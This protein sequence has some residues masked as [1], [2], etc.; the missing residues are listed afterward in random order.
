[1]ATYVVPQIWI[2]YDGVVS[3]NHWFVFAWLGQVA[4]TDQC[5]TLKSFEMLNDRSSRLCSSGV[6]LIQS[7]LTRSS[8][9]NKKPR[10]SSQSSV[11]QSVVVGNSWKLVASSLLL[12]TNSK[13]SSTDEVRNL[14]TWGT[15]LLRPCRRFLAISAMSMRWVSTS[16]PEFVS[17]TGDESPLH[18]EVVE[19]EDTDLMFPELFRR[20]LRSSILN[21]L[22]TASYAVSPPTALV[23]VQ[24]LDIRI[25]VCA[26][27]DPLYHWSH[28]TITRNVIGV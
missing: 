8:K 22:S 10:L 18:D 17:V 14:L 9:L 27:H 16:L 6:E 20:I 21:F 3:S 23:N 1:M 13:V 25:T 19:L 24:L 28:R 5:P 4:I 2:W 26:A 11:E 15:D 7:T 12:K